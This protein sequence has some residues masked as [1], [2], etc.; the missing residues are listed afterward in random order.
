M[1]VEPTLHKIQLILAAVIKDDFKE[2]ASL[3]ITPKIKL[4]HAN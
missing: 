4:Q 1:L 3:R 2:T